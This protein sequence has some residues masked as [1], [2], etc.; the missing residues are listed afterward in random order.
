MIAPNIRNEGEE[1][2]PYMN[3]RFGSTSWTK[4]LK[5]EGR[6]DGAP[7]ANWKWC[8]N[9]LKAH[10]LIQYANQRHDV[11]TSTSNAALFKAL[12]EEGENIGLVDTL[13]EIAQK[14]LGIATSESEESSLRQYLQEDQGAMEVKQ[15]I[16]SGQAKYKISGVPFF[17]IEKE[18]DEDSSPPYGL[19][20]AQKPSTFTRV[21][22]ELNHS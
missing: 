5:Q 17:I 3:R 18:G 4:R 14:D 22:E 7:F 19:S 15:E 2:E 1:F 21:F 9:T 8:S 11:D 6:L 12:Y 20:G 13:L 16:Q 10:Q